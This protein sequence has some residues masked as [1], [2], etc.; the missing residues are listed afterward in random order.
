LR[1]ET[2]PSRPN[3]QALRKRWPVFQLPTVTKINPAKNNAK[4]SAFK[5]GCPILAVGAGFDAR[6]Q[7]H[8]L[9][10]ALVGLRPRH[11]FQRVH[12]GR[13]DRVGNRAFAKGPHTDAALK[14]YQACA[15]LAAIATAFASGEPDGTAR[16]RL[17]WPA[18]F[19]CSLLLK[20]RCNIV[21]HRNSRR[22]LSVTEGHER[23]RRK[24]A[25]SIP[26]RNSV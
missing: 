13:A 6:A 10:L 2:R 3:S 23:S 9:R 25:R 8:E 20:P 5:F 19:Q 21:D 11:A 22:H 4:R 26:C 12:G 17:A 18:A 15:L 1:F 7:R 16:A 14:Q 24:N